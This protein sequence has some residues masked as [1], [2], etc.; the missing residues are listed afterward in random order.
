MGPSLPGDDDD[1]PARRF[2]RFP[3]Y[4]VLVLI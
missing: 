4:F 2:I 3:N 1:C